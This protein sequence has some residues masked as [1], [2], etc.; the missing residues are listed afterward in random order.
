MDKLFGR[1]KPKP[2]PAPATNINAP[3][4]GETSQKVSESLIDHFLRLCINN[5][6]FILDG[7]TQQGD[8]S[9]DR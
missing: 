2:E 8:S 6:M 4:L 1:S 3:S 5:Q 7:P 9:K